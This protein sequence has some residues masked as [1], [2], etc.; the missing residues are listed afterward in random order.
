MADYPAWAD[1]IQTLLRVFPFDADSHILTDSRPVAGQPLL[2]SE[3]GKVLGTDGK[4][5]LHTSDEAK[6]WDEEDR[7]VLLVLQLKQGPL[8]K[9]YT[10]KARTVRESWVALQR[11]YA[12]KSN[13][14]D[15][16]Y[17][18]KL[19]TTK[20]TDSDDIEEHI[21]KLVSIHNEIQDVQTLVPDALFASAILE[22]L[23]PSY[24]PLVQT[25]SG[26]DRTTLKSG[27]V[28]TEV[29]LEY[30]RRLDRDGPV[31]LAAK[32]NIPRSRTNDECRYCHQRGHWLRECPTLAAN[33]GP[34]PRP[35]KASGG[36]NRNGGGGKA[37]V[38]ETEAE[39]SETANLVVAGYLDQKGDVLEY[40]F[41]AGEQA[42]A[43]GTG[44]EKWIGDSGAGVHVVTNRDLFHS[45]RDTQGTLDGVG[46]RPILGRGDVKVIM[47]GPDGDSH[48]TLRDAVHV[49]GLPYNLISLARVTGDCIET[50]LTHTLTIRDHTSGRITWG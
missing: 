12:P 31:A 44:G 20:P 37:N 28:I 27:D 30:Q 33:G 2:D 47:H 19:F 38:A 35:N 8:P 50:T 32:P 21:N 24:D 6:Q 10:K 34:R 7:L 41:I 36:G 11:I 49:A 40:A 45:Y 1:A 14:T 16:R 13:T 29:I 17:L 3:G 22:S 4:Q 43:A 5:I 46:S 39:K 25:F 48:I 9:R 18:T 26:K 15:M 23:P 42:L